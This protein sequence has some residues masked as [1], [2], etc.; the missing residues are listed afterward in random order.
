MRKWTGWRWQRLIKR[1][2]KLAQK[3]MFSTKI[4][5]SDAFL[6]MPLSTQCLYF[7]LNMRA[8]DDGFVGNPKKIQRIIGASED[9]LK[10][11]IGK[12]FLLTFDDGVIV[13][14]HWRIHNCIS[15]NR[16]H[17]TQYTDQKK[18]LLLK[19]NKAYSFT[20]GQPVD[21]KRLTNGLQSAVPGLGLDLDLDLGL[22]LDLE[23]DT[24]E[25]KD[26]KENK[27]KKS[28][29]TETMGEMFKRLSHN[30]TMSQPLTD[31][32]NEWLIYKTE[33]KEK[34]QE[35]GMK[36]LLTVITKNAAQVGDNSVINLIDECMSSNWRGIIWDKLGSQNQKGSTYM[37]SI[38]N[39]VSEVDNWV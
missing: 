15:Q 18:A 35:Q 21:D 28:S 34:Y 1:G 5:D 24:E 26:I 10:L 20:H 29:K 36:S 25:D 38:K 8:D 6:D 32:I 31:K 4:V 9:D 7:H 14:K 30:Y 37:N 12:R 22:E 16:Y 33:R 2:D 3:R 11:L 23:L 19:D 17:E 27:K 13:I 39:R